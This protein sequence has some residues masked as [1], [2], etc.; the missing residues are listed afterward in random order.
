MATLSGKWTFNKVLTKPDF[1]AP[2][3]T[4]MQDI[5][6]SNSHPIDGKYSFAKDKAYKIHITA[7]GSAETAY[8][9]LKIDGELY[10]NIYKYEFKPTVN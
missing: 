7:T 9:I 10:Y 4:N 5:R 2:G 1:V 8:C 3:Q 6:F